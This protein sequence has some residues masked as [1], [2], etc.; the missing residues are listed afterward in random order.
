MWKLP[1]EW[2]EVEPSVRRMVYGLSV[3]VMLVLSWAATAVL[4]VKL[5]YG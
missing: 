2:L 3:I 1:E 4:I 5:K